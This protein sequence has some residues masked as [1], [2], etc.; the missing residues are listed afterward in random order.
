MWPGLLC[1]LKVAAIQS[2]LRI[3]FTWTSR[4]I[5]V[6]S[7]EVF[8]EWAETWEFST[9]SPSPCLSEKPLNSAS[10]LT[11]AGISHL[12]LELRLHYK[13]EACYFA[14]LERGVGEEHFLLPFLRLSWQLAALGAGVGRG[15][16]LASV[17]GEAEYAHKLHKKCLGV[18]F[19]NN[20]SGS[21]GQRWWWSITWSFQTF[22][23]ILSACNT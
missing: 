10:H 18:N 6:D 11:G 14:L 12:L 4:Y 15:M 7:S 21:C 13:T 2:A 1:C 19:I 17:I 8:S 9:L 3:T 23:C 5:E 22:L 20:V 16:N